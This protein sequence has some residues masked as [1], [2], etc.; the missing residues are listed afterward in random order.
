MSLNNDQNSA[1]RNMLVPILE[2]AGLV[3]QTKTATYE[4]D[5]SLSDLRDM[6]RLFWRTMDTYLGPAYLDHFWMYAD[7][8][9]LEDYEAEAA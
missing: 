5:I 9:A 4:G 8:N 6:M 2:G 3:R 7:R 1:L